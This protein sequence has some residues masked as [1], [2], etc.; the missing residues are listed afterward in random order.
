MSVLKPPLLVDYQQKVGELVIS[1][2][3]CNSSIILENTL[4]YCIETMAGGVQIGS[5]W[6]RIGTC[7]GLL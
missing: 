6:L 3:Y 1:T 7:G 5:S 4:N 2:T